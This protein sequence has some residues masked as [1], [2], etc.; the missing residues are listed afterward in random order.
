MKKFM[1]RAVILPLI[2]IIALL[3]VIIAVK[4]RPAIEHE[5]LQFATRTVEVITARKLPFRARAMAYGHVEPVVLLKA[6]TEISGKVSYIHPD[7]KKGASLA[8]DTVVLRI[9]PTTFEFSLDQSKAGLTSS[10]S[11]LKQLDVE[12]T[13]SRRSLDIA[14]KNLD[15]GQKELDRF[16]ILWEKRVITRS[17]LDGE[18]QKVLQLSQQVEEQEGKLAAFASRR[19][20][21]KAQIKKS[22]V[23]LA[24]SQDTL[25]RTEISLPFDARIGTVSVEK[26]EFVAVGSLLFEA[27]GI[28]AVEVSAALPVSQFSPLI[29]GLGKDVLNLQRPEDFQRAFSQMQIGA[30]VSL[31]GDKRAQ[32]K[33]QGKFLRIGESIDPTRNTVSLVVAINNPYENIIPG[34]RP[35]LLKGMFV[36]V[37]FFAPVREMMVLPRKALHQGRLYVASPGNKLEIRPVNILHKQGQ[38]VVIDGGI[39]EGERIIITDVIPVIEGLP[40]N[41]IPSADYEKQLAKDALGDFGQVDFEERDGE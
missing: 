28:Q 29:A 38:L 6:R 22:R 21:I 34:K 11:S 32:A 39:R 27:L 20:A 19:A 1:K 30:N 15:I 12:E 7:L 24:Q 17:T 3:I 2:F 37:E 9:E 31:V 5:E 14:R 40:L 13:S 8:K 16:L 33:W 36:A 35:P 18:Q 25:G 10:Q 41:P 26:G 4:S 23:Q